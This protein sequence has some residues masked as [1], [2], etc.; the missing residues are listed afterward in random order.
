MNLIAKE[1]RWSMPATGRWCSEFVGAHDELGLPAVSVNPFDI[2]DRRTHTAEALE[3][4][5]AERAQGGSAVGQCA[6]T[7]AH[8]RS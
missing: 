8:G 3:M 6:S 5:A 1:A 7:P 4:P 2:Q